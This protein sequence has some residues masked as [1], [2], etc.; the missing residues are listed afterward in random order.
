MA[1]TLNRSVIAGGVV[2]PA[3]TAVTD[4]LLAKIPDPSVWDGDVD[5][6]IEPVDNAAWEAK[7]EKLTADF[8]A[9]VDEKNATIE[10]LTGELEQLK[11][12]QGDGNPAAKPSGGRAA[13]GGVVPDYSELD[14]EALKAEIDKRNEGREN[15]AKI[16]KR[17]SVETLAAALV[18]DDADGD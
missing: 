10:A 16:S 17:G 11:A 6:A 1:A 9:V 4:D 13:T 5:L 15:D 8:K 14:I 3:G 7:V 12:A 2:Y 18:S